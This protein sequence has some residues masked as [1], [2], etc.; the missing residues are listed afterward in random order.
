MAVLCLGLVL[1]AC[2]TPD[3]IA[4][5]RGSLGAR[6]TG[7]ILFAQDGDIYVWTDGQSTQVID[8]GNA[9]MPD[10]S[11][12]G[13]QFVFVRTGDGYSDLWVANADGSNQRQLTFDKPDIQVGTEAYVCYAAWALDP[14]WSPVD[15]TIAFVSDRGSSCPQ[16]RPNYLWLM[17]G[18]G[19][20][21]QQV[22]AS[23]LNGDNVEHPS[24]SPDGSEIVFA[25]RVTG[26]NMLQRWTQL[27]IVELATG[28]LI[29]LVQGEQ[30]AYAPVWSPDGEWIA[31]IQRD[32]TANDLWIVPA[33]GGEPVRL[34]N[35]GD[36]TAPAWSPD[37]TAIAFLRAD[38]LGFKAVYVPFSVDAQGVPTAGKAQD[39]FSADNIDAASGLSW[40]E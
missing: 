38:G 27:W 4:S 12:D 28:R 34:T 39:L 21:P 36:V 2:G 10:W 22:Y 25:Q 24:F 18:L 7:K 15:D 40:A 17:P 6:P 35:L 30:A 1:A 13:R 32:G 23:T 33:T 5:G 8:S 20:T 3:P 37:G 9:S 11:F 29:P 14:V 26:D 19:V 16:A 31:F